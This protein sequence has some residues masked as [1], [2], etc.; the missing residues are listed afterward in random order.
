[1]LLRKSCRCIV[2]Y[3]LKT[4]TNVYILVNVLNT[5]TTMR[6]VLRFN[7][8]FFQPPLQPGQEEYNNK[9]SDTLADLFISHGQCFS[10]VNP[11]KNWNNDSMNV[12]NSGQLGKHGFSSLHNLPFLNGEILLRNWLCFQTKIHLLKIDLLGL[13]DK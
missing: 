11:I 7:M 5:M 4:K 12:G 10:K 3:L 6:H 9:Y 2:I 1:M 8:A 13:S